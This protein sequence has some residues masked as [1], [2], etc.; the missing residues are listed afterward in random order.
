M[1]L[2][3]IIRSI[4]QQLIPIYHT[5]DAANSNAWW[6]L[7]KLTGKN[8]ISLIAH[9][10]NITLTPEQYAQLEEWIRDITINHKPIQYILGSVPFGQL[11]IIVEPPI[12]IPRPETEEWV[13]NLIEKIK[14]SYP[15]G[16]VSPLSILDLC[17]GSGC[18]GLSLAHAFPES[19]IYATDIN[20]AALSLTQRN[21]YLLGI[22]NIECFQ[23]DLFAA[24]EKTPQ[25]FDLILA[26]PPYISPHELPM[27]EPSVRHWE[28]SGALIAKDNGLALIKEIITQAPDFLSPNIALA[29]HNVPQLIIEIGYQQ[30]HIVQ[31]YMIKKG[32][33]SVTV[34]AD[35]MGN[36]RT[37]AGSVSHVAITI[38][39]S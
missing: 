18:I 3:K 21:A 29:A 33:T 37:V 8:K 27:L 25:K 6:L 16:L 22:T 10:E 28:D 20:P 9:A 30:G 12:L 1:I 14:N 24:F 7:E 36:D 11:D 26:N 38:N 4:T 32:Y 5:P 17:T 2:N 23:S 15:G 31:D 34:S 39:N 13:M 35:Q 19:R